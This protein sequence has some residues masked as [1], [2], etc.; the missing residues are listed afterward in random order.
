[1][2][3]RLATICNGVL[4]K[5]F[6]G[7]ALLLYSRLRV[8]SGCKLAC[9]KPW[10]SSAASGKAGCHQRNGYSA[11]KI[12]LVLPSAESLTQERSANHRI[13]SLQAFV[14]IYTKEDTMTKRAVSTRLFAALAAVALAFCVLPV[15][16]RAFT[17]DAGTTVYITRYGHAYHIY[18]DCPT[19]AGHVT[20]SIAFGNR[21]SR[22][23]CDLCEARYE[24]SGGGSLQNSSQ[25]QNAGWVASNGRWWYRNADGSYPAN[26]WQ[27]I[28]GSW[29]HFDAQ[30]WM[31]T[32]WLKDGGTWYYLSPSG[33]M[34]TG[35]Q[36]IDGSWYYFNAS[37]AMQTG[38]IN[39]GGTWYYLSSSGAMVTGWQQIDGSWYY[40]DGS[41]AMYANRWCGDYYLGSSGAML[42][43]AWT[44]DGYYVGSDGRWIPASADSSYE[45]ILADYSAR[46]AAATPG[47]VDEYN[48]EYSAYSTI[49]D[50]AA[51]SNAKIEK[52]A[53]IEN[54]GTEKMAEH[55]FAA[56]DSYSTYQSWA[57]KL[58]N[59]YEQY[60]QQI[61]DA[62]TASCS[63]LW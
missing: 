15:Q 29:Y 40:F 60:A 56:D 22:D 8:A 6:H 38:W 24:K 28:D 42:T 13:E 7:E 11:E 3:V 52:L 58:N 17:A 57:L 61:T 16:A 39:L 20:T 54:E 53:A 30:G 62:Y 34:A 1:M 63:N 46:I 25:Q 49:G 33:A 10:Q 43:N 14:Q 50:R 12:S 44:P 48:A 55:H 51:L 18:S 31:Q 26:C 9:L 4:W 45:L 5:G 2:G 37:G 27:K 32:G 36:K 19:L 23:V 59:V 47:L 41:G 21:G 35:W